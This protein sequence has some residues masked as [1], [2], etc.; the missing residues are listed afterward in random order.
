MLE[1]NSLILPLGLD[2][3]LRSG[4]EPFFKTIRPYPIRER[5]L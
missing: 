5:G 3:E 1:L 4:Y 2:I